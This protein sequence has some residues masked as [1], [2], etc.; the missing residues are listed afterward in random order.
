MDKDSFQLL[1]ESYSNVDWSEKE[2][3]LR[4]EIE[5][6]FLLYSTRTYCSSCIEMKERGETSGSCLWGLLQSDILME[7]DLF[8]LT[9]P[10]NPNGDAIDHVIHYCYALLYGHDGFEYN[11]P[12]LPIC[13]E[14][15]IRMAFEDT[16][17]YDIHD[18]STVC[19][20]VSETCTICWEEELGNINKLNKKVK[21]EIHSSQSE[22]SAT[23]NKEEKKCQV[24]FDTT[25]FDLFEEYSYGGY[26][27]PVT[28]N[29]KRKQSK[30][31]ETTI[32]LNDEKSNWSPDKKFKFRKV[33]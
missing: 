25:L 15:G 5:Q 30:P 8:I 10:T 17:S 27:S 26:C 2:R 24:V 14:S 1:K 29:K 3:A 21:S 18:R 23:T 28:C 22:S 20:S 32:T 9:H 12:P 19:S 7:G 33:K 31:H 6:Q 13:V 16:T 4:N 11:C